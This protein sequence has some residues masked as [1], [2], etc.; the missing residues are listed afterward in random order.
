MDQIKESNGKFEMVFAG[1]REV[2][3]TSMGG[4]TPIINENFSLYRAMGDFRNQGVLAKRSVAELNAR[5]SSFLGGNSV[6]QE[7]LVIILH[8]IYTEFKKI[9]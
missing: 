9:E 6:D 7:N 2:I 4:N 3:H 1:K 5:V 8:R